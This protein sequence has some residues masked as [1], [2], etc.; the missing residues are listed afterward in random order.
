MPEVDTG[1]AAPDAA[2]A[3]AAAAAA[4]ANSNTASW[5]QGADAETL[6]HIQNRGWQDK[7]AN[8]VALAAIKAHREAEKLIGVPADQLLR[9]P[10]STADA[11]AW[12]PVWQKLGAPVDA[13]GYDFTPIKTAAGEAPN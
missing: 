6:G 7:P 8:E 9:L 12:K 1:N 5:H 2:A 3:A 13:A 11:E 4:L 10:V